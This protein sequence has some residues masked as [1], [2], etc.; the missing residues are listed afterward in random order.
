MVPSM[1]CVFPILNGICGIIAVDPKT[2]I[3]AWRIPWTVE[4]SRLQSMGSQRVRHDWGTN[5]FIFMNIYTLIGRV[6]LAV[7]NLPANAGH[8][9]DVSLIPGLGRAPEAGTATYSSIL[10][11]RIPWTEEPAALVNRVAKSG[12]RLKRLS[13]HACRWTRT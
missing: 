2:S 11:W 6:A 7:R 4:P 8:I 1:S 9:R 13:S 10:A 12:T 3:L 5:T